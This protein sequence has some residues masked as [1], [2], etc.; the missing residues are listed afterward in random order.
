MGA[1]NR[2]PQRTNVLLTMISGGV[3]I[4]ATLVLTTLLMGQSAQRAAREAVRMV[5]NFYLQELAGRRE[6][7]VSSN[8]NDNISNMRA[9][10][11]Q[12]DEDDLSSPARLR[13]WQARIKKLYN[14]EKFAFVDTSGLIYTSLGLE[15]TISEYH[16]DYN[17]IREPEISIKN[18]ESDSKK[19]IIAIP[20]DNLSFNGQT[21]VASF[22]E[23]DMNRLL[24][25]VSIQSDANGAT[26]C[27]LYYENGIPLTGVVLGGL[28]S[29]SNLLLSLRDAEF[30][31]RSSLAQIEDD[32][33]NSREGMISFT[34][35]GASENMYYIPVSNTNWMLTYLI[36]ESM[37]SDQI[38][39]ISQGIIT[40][41]LVQTI[42]TVAA[43]L[44]VFSVIITQNRKET[45]LTMERETMEAENRVKQQELEERLKLQNQLLEQERQNDT[46]RILHGML[47]SGPWFMDFDENGVITSVTWTET[48]RQMLGYHSQED[49][50]D[51]LES[52]SDLL[53]PDDKERVL[54]EYNDTIRDYTGQ[55]VYDVEYRL[56]TKDRGWRWFHAVG[57]LTRRPDGSPITYIGI[58]VDITERKNMEQQLEEQQESLKSALEQAEQANAA[59]TS[60]LSSMSHEIRTP[61]NAII[62]L[63]SIALKDPGLTERTREHLE[64]I[65]G[66]AKHLLGLRKRTHDPEK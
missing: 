19:V 27:N 34:Y 7:V 17:T 38:Q 58:F 48:F 56:M 28:S 9:A 15:Y 64:K 25:G 26:F 49:F 31:S 50:P 29:D 3:I 20:V 2:S 12:L 41:S 59:K 5:S 13:A 45:R 8:L 22:I 62:G 33:Q 61:M 46:M 42:I 37:I 63:D 1:E 16:F 10:I 66:S 47:N 30:A 39:P 65:G 24:E 55:K 4:A 11:E 54:K 52:W 51:R 21:L 60:F 53:H 44:V 36:Q 6:Q 35:H 40:R 23:I 43:L 32:F 57:Q 14:L 18:L